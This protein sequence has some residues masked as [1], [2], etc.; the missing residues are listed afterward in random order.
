MQ[1]LINQVLPPIANQI[2][3]Q[4]EIMELNIQIAMAKQRLLIL[5]QLK[6]EKERTVLSV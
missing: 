6:A 1:P 4:G 5:E 2:K 3:I